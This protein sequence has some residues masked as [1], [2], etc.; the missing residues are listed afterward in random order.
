MNN[1]FCNCTPLKITQLFSPSYARNKRHTHKKFL[2]PCNIVFS[3]GFNKTLHPKT[4]CGWGR[5]QAEE[6]IA[7][8]WRQRRKKLKFV[9]RE[10][11]IFF[12]KKPLFSETIW[13]TLLLSETTCS[14]HETNPPPQNPYS[15]ALGL[16]SLKFSFWEFL[17]GEHDFPASLLPPQP[18]MPTEMLLLG[19]GTPHPCPPQEQHGRFRRLQWERGIGENGSPSICR[20]HLPD[21][22]QSR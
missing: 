22:T 14:F 18:R 6:L 10:M 19:R 21:P 4:F 11:M 3:L 2:D 16:D 13:Q 12:K 17:T 15:K 1:S 20:N 8:K 7:R 5:K 9:K